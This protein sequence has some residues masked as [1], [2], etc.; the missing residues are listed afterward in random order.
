MV[1]DAC[2]KLPLI[3]GVKEHSYEA[4]LTMICTLAT[5]EV[6]FGFTRDAYIY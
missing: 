2:I 4:H 3:P 6:Q 5:Q 1:V